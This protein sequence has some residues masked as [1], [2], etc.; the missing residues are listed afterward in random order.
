M[1]EGSLVVLNIQETLCKYLLGRRRNGK[2]QKPRIGNTVRTEDAKS[3]WVFHDS[4]L[5]SIPKTLRSVSKGL[6]ILGRTSQF[7]I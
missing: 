3:I 4:T 7:R 6:E 1:I 5:H 2:E